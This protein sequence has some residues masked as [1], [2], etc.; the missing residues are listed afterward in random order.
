MQF[1]NLADGLKVDLYIRNIDVAISQSMFK[2]VLVYTDL[3]HYFHIHSAT[4]I[5]R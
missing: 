2:Y 4:F 3:Q 5:Y 1:V